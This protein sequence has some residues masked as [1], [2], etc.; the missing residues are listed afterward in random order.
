[1]GLLSWKKDKD[2]GKIVEKK[3]TKTDVAK[4]DIKKEEKKRSMKDL[5]AKKGERKKG[6]VAKESVATKDLYAGKQGIK[7]GEEDKKKKREYGNAHKVLLKPLVTEKASVLGAENKYV[8]AV[9]PRANKIEVAKAVDE[10]YGIQPS[11]VNIIKVKGKKVRYGRITGKRKDWKKAIVTLP[12]GESINIY[13][14]V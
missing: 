10:V 1:M 12:A 3:S 4:K 5:Y 11:S 13:E 6:I 7:R 14:G 9:A 2:K 8:F